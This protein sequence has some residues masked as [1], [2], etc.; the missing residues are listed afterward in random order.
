MCMLAEAHCSWAGPWDPWTEPAL[1]RW[2]RAPSA[3]PAPC[4]LRPA[5]SALQ[6][7]VA[8]RLECGTPLSSRPKAPPHNFS[9]TLVGCPAVLRGG[10]SPAEP[11]PVL[12]TWMTATPRE[13]HCW[14]AR[15]MTHS[16]RLRHVWNLNP[17]A[18]Q[19]RHLGTQA[20]Y[21]AVPQGGIL[22]AEPIL[23]LSTRSVS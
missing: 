13:V 1:S 15:A 7:G 6:P 5:G 18:L 12:A 10:T 22:L 23:G 16:L 14:L 19:H 17:S 8:G 3:D 11:A 4:S 20:G 9:K 2:L 21:P